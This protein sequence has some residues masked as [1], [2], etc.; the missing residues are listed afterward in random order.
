MTQDAGLDAPPPPLV[1][2][3]VGATATGKSAL[4]MALAELLPGGGE[5]VNAD[6]LQVY[7]GFDLGT[8]KPGAALRLRVPHH[9][10][11]VLDPH[12]RWSA[13]EFARR[14]RLA[15]AAIRGRGRWPIVVGGSGLYLRA[16]LSG[17]SP[18]PAGDPEVR[19]RLRRRAAEEG[20]PTLAAELAGLDPVTAARLAPGDRQ[21]VLRALEV[22]LVSGRPLSAW[23][24][25]QPFGTQSIAAIRVGL[26]LP[27]S[28]LYDRIAGRVDRM[29]ESG[30]LEE[31]RGL[32]EHGL[33]PGLPAFQA[34]GYRQMVHH[35]RGEWPLARV[36]DETVRATR[37]FAK[38]QETWFR[39]EPD[40]TWFS[41]EDLDR[42]IPLILE[43]V[44]RALGEG[45]E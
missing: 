18:I 12:E 22:A 15:I 40:V 36:V 21:R 9:L 13:G 28:I 1:V 29:V 17:I 38:R 30:W 16:L 5:I 19:E 43:H 44:Q 27:R 3:V 24:A 14:A 34:I 11:D 39:S 32:I 41:A 26:T 25:S 4:G 23:I 10:I 37:R 31:V 45:R 8:A 33:D 2:A 20:L 7:R 6:A 35:V 42:R